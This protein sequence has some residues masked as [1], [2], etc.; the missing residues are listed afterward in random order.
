MTRPNRETGRPSQPRDFEQDLEADVKGR[1][2]KELLALAVELAERRPLPRPGLRSAIRS[3]L[4][5]R[6]E[7]R[8]PARLG[9]LIFA[10][11]SAGAMLL[12]IAAAGLVGIGPFAA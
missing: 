3:R 4:L 6:G 9:A 8:A 2:R 7:R 5:S 1:E 11:G 12:A 10:Y